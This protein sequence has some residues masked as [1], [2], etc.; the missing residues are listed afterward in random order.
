MH[1]HE[2]T[3]LEGFTHALHAA[4]YRGVRDLHLSTLNGLHVIPAEERDFVNVFQSTI[5]GQWES[6]GVFHCISGARL[7][8]DG[9]GRAR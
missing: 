4:V 8:V 3:T 9:D 5:R 1:R 7:I 6:P 2:G